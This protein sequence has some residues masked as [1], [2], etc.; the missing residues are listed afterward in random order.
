MK[1]TWLILG[2]AFALAVVSGCNSGGDGSTTTTND[3]NSTSTPQT[4][5]PIVTT[6]MTT[7][8]NNCTTATIAHFYISPTSDSSWGVDRLHD[9]LVAG[10]HISIGDL[11]PDHYDM[12]V[13][14]STDSN[15]YAY[16]ANEYIGVGDDDHVAANDASFS[17]AIK[18]VN[19]S[20]NDIISELYVVPSPVAGVAWGNDLMAM[21]TPHYLS[22]PGP[23]GSVQ[24]TDPLANMSAGLYDI[25]MVSSTGHPDVL[26]KG[27]D[28]H[29]VTVTP[30]TLTIVNDFN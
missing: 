8:Y 23:G 24:V 19:N 9:D 22:L 17:G 27:V 14:V 21:T 13:I 26:L 10:D 16:L 6:G 5:T 2:F 11:P 28:G 15:Y 29:G 20:L 3:N 18:I 1:K 25:K 12:M 4:E 30:L 7:L